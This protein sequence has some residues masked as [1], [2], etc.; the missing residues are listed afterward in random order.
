MLEQSM[1]GVLAQR[2]ID[3]AA[4][5]YALQLRNETLSI[6][7]AHAMLLRPGLNLFQTAGLAKALACFT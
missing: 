6:P 7:D 2:F 5:F 3:K 1:S 4:Q